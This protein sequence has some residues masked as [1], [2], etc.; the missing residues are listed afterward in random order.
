[1]RC[2]QNFQVFTAADF[3]AATVEHI[4]PKG[5]QTIR[6]YGRYSNKRRGWDAKHRIRPPV[7]I[8]GTMRENP[9]PTDPNRSPTLFILPPPE[10]KFARLDDGT[11]LVLD[12]DPLPPD[13]FP[14]SFAN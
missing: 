12:A 13:E 1:M 4:P 5:Q 11:I 7:V 6:Y 8:A 3:I 9:K 14:V 10:K 2:K